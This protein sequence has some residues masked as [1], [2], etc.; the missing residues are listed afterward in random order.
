MTREEHLKFCAVC[1]KRSFNP[2]F[3]I[4]CS[5]TQEVASFEGSC[6]DYSEDAHEVN[7]QS[8]QK[9]ELKSETNKQ[10]N[11]GRI[12]LFLVAGLYL[13]TGIWEG[14]FIAGHELI[15]GIID[16][17]VAG[18]FLG[19]GLWS[20]RQPLIAMIVGL[21]VYALIILLLAMIDPSTLY[22]G[23]IWKILIILYLGYGI[24]TARHEVVQKKVTNDDILDQ[25]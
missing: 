5:L 18:I 10:L 1:T 4:V 14:F 23:I 25:M 8:L 22:Q 3:G 11:R 2:K 15:F 12:A 19:L 13:L 21:S 9:K 17:A 7:M 6:P 24:Q 16:W 20:Y